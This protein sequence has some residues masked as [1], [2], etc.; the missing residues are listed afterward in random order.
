MVLV[1]RMVEIRVGGARLR[2]ME[3]LI[4]MR[5]LSVKPGNE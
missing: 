3:L 4:V 1:V 2:L 5:I